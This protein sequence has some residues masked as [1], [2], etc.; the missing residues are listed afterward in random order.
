MHGAGAHARAV[1]F[2]LCL[3]VLLAARAACAGDVPYPFSFEEAAVAPGIVAFIE[4]PGHAIVSGNSIAIAGD[5]AIAVVDTG[6]H[7][8][9]TRAMIARLR[10]SMKK[11]VRYVINTH[12]HNDHVAGNALYAEAFPDARFVAQAFTARMLESE[13]AP[14]MHGGCARFLERESAPLRAAVAS[15]KAADGSAIAPARV[16]RLREVIEEADVAAAECGE[17]RLRGSDIAFEERLTLELGHRDVQVLFLGRANTAGDAIVYVPDAKVVMTGDV[18]VHPFPFATQSYIR[19]WAAVLRRIEAM[20]ADTIV[21]GHG[22]VMHDKVYLGLVAELMES[23]DGQ[24]GAAWRPGMALDELREH[25]DL[26]GFRARIAG[27]SGFI[28]ANFD[29]M[30]RSAVERAWQEREGKLAPEGL[31]RG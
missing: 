2:L 19:E 29:A 3:G 27:D 16:S 25:V 24:V 28:G 6:Q 15:G 21:P 1:R 11:P 26:A 13:I 12:W 9:L 4:K 17:F 10:E 14:Y 5:D 18:L 20:D 30:A 23:I 22:P 31:P 8:R 7:P